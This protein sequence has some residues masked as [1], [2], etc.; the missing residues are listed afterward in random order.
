MK[1][2]FVAPVRA[3]IPGRHVYSSLISEG[4]FQ[5]VSEQNPASPAAAHCKKAVE[6]DCTREEILE[7]A[8]MAMVFGGSPVLASSATLLLDCLDTFCK[9]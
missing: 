7:A 5:E 2:L 9:G 4:A 3:V 6:A 8:G 1:R